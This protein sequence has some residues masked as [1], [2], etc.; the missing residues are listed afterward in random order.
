MMRE[1]HACL[2]CLVG[3]QVVNK[4]TNKPCYDSDQMSPIRPESAI[5]NYDSKTKQD[6]YI[7][8]EIFGAQE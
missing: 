3:K 6:D 8:Q 7:M 2:L 1:S 5:M 4:Q